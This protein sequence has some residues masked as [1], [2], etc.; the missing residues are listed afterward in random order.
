MFNQQN[1]P[2][3]ARRG[4]AALLR[5]GISLLYASF[6][7]RMDMAGTGVQSDARGGG[8]YFGHTEC[9]TIEPQGPT[10]LRTG[11]SAASCRRGERT[12]YLGG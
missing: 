12:G 8:D 4:E 5:K 1:F 3:K 11:V 7:G 6:E 2:R 10:E 9:E